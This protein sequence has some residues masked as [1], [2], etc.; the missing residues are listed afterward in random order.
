MRKSVRSVTTNITETK[1][2]KKLTSR[3][4]QTLSKLVSEMKEN[5]L[6]TTIIMTAID[7]F[8]LENGISLDKFS[9]RLDVKDLCRVLEFLK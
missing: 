5:V 8:C 4:E 2:T 9:E 1:E 6:Q 7:K 3:Q